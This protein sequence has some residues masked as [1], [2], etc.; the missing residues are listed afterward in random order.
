MKA[1][2]SKESYEMVQKLANRFCYGNTSTNLYESYVNVGLDA[3]IKTTET[4]NGTDA[5]FSTYLYRCVQNALISEKR[6]MDVREMQQ[7]ENID[8]EVYEGAA[9]EPTDERMEK[10]LKAFINK[11]TDGNERNAEIVSLHIGLN[12]DPMELKEIA[13]QFQLSHEMVRLVCTKA[14]KKIR[15]DKAARQIL[16]SFVG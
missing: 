16:F 8:L 1:A 6:K 10:Y 7:D 9:Y 2:I 3:L 5:Q 4:Y 11:A 12:C 15:E 13:A 14:I